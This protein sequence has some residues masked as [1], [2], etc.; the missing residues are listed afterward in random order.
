MHL[1][2]YNVP[3]GEE[4]AELHLNADDFPNNTL[5]LRTVSDMFDV[6]D[7]CQRDVL[8]GIPVYLYYYFVQIFQLEG[9]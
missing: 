1:T 5:A 9:R 2:V 6:E 4:D 3:K 8:F 7:L